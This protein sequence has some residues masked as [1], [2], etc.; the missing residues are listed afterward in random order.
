MLKCFLPAIPSLREL[1]EMD[2][3]ISCA[4]QPTVYCVL[5]LSVIC[6]LVS[7]AE[8]CYEQC[9]FGETFGL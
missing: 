6:V 9:V 8:R 4:G 3:Q 5:A 2:M 7:T 1:R